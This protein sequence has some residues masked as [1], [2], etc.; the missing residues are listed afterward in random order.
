MK[1]AVLSLSRTPL[2]VEA[3]H[4]GDP[5]LLDHVMAD[6]RLGSRTQAR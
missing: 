6:R 3:L 4:A 2:V 1:D 5:E